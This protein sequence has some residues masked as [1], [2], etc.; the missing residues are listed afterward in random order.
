MQQ[1]V[2]AMKEPKMTIRS[3]QPTKQNIVMTTT[4]GHKMAGELPN[5]IYAIIKFCTKTHV[6]DA[7]VVSK[8]AK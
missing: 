7:V 4:Y 6:T 8:Q 1:K 3:T 5:V 2:V